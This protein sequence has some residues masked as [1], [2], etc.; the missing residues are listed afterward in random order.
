MY[1]KIT[2]H[3]NYC[4]RTALSL[5]LELYLVF[6]WES[7][8]LL[9]LTSN[10]LAS[11]CC[12]FYSGVWEISSALLFLSSSTSFHMLGLTLFFCF[13][14]PCHLSLFLISKSKLTFSFLINWDIHSGIPSRS[15]CSIGVQVHALKN[16]KKKLL[17]MTYTSKRTTLDNCDS[18]LPQLHLYMYNQCMAYF[19]HHTTGAHNRECMRSCT[20]CVRAA[21]LF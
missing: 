19:L 14:N 16:C 13:T 15:L 6:V 1:G 7:L 4:S 21:A 2:I 18:D 10:L 9:W 5:S 20:R 12:C 3:L 17:G 8:L 11:S